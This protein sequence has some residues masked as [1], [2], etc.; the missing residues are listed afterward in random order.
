MLSFPESFVDTIGNWRYFWKCQ[1]GSN[2]VQLAFLPAFRR[3]VFFRFGAIPK[4]VT[5]FRIPIVVK[6]SRIHP[7]YQMTS[8]RY[9]NLFNLLRMKLPLSVYNKQFNSMKVLFLV[10]ISWLFCLHPLLKQIQSQEIWFP[11]LLIHFLTVAKWSTCIIDSVH[12][13]PLSPSWTGDRLTQ[14]LM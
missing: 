9:L 4:V 11:T 7:F 3:F 2:F 13:S 10:H 1:K 8:L 6:I 14:G 5:I 12:P